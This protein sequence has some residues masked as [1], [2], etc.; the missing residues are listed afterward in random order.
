MDFI[1]KNRLK[2][3]KCHQEFKRTFGTSLMEF[4]SFFYGFDVVKF[5]E[6]IAQPKEG[7]STKDAVEKKFGKDAVVLCER[8]L[9]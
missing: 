1:A 6:Q 5:D 4:F 8:L 7:Q 9:T 3:Q 2:A